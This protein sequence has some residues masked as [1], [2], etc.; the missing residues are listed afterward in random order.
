MFDSGWEKEGTANGI[1]MYLSVIPFVGH[2]P[3]P[4][5]NE[6]Y[7]FFVQQLRDTKF[8]IQCQGFMDPLPSIYVL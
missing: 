3:F 5:S 1:P 7:G 8:C 4:D 2:R 6:C